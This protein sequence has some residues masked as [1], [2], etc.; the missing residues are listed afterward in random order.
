MIYEVSHRT[1]Y[2]YG[3]PVARSHHLVHLA[4]RTVRH[5]TNLNHVLMID[6]APATRSDII[7]YFGNPVSVLTIDTEHTSLSFH[8]RSIIE[9]KPREAVFLAATSPWEHVAARL[10]Q[11][12]NNYDLGVLQYAC[13]SP[14]TR[15]NDDIKAYAMESFGQGR[16]LLEAVSELN[17]RINEDFAYDPTVTDVT[18][19]VDEVFAIKGG[20]CQ[21]FAHFALTCLRALDLPARY[22]SGYLLTH[23][24]EGQQ[25]ML[26]ADATHAWFSVWSPETG[27]IDFDPTNNLMPSDEHIT[28]A[29][30]RDFGDVSPIG[31]VLLGG[32]DH[33]VEVGVDVLPVQQGNLPGWATAGE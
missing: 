11:K 1:I 19:S 10:H 32:D 5:Q 30:G 14:H 6:P 22:V 13:V 23:P 12:T 9:V 7:D 4:P 28:I 27:W 29:Y 2:H 33:S 25:K 15:P 17:A 8:A 31:G 24:P 20:V 18:T 16:P 3:A 26:G 21:D